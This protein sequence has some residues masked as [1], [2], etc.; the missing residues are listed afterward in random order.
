M[1]SETH[2]NGV[3]FHIL[4]QNG[5]SKDVNKFFK[6]LKNNTAVVRANASSKLDGF[7]INHMYEWRQFFELKS[8]PILL[9][10]MVW[11]GSQAD[12]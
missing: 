3:E 6:R 7:Q 5:H 10:I 2:S 9:K 12:K 1:H 8:G 4:S 11:F